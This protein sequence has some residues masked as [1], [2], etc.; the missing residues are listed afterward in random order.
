MFIRWPPPFSKSPIQEDDL[1]PVEQPSPEWMHTREPVLVDLF[2]VASDFLVAFRLAEPFEHAVCTL[3]RCGLMMTLC[4]DRPGVSFGG[5][6]LHIFSRTSRPARR[7]SKPALV[8][9]NSRFRRSPRFSFAPPSDEVNR[10]LSCKRYNVAW[11]AP[12]VMTR[13]VCASISFLTVTP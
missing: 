5:I 10:P 11:T 12:S 13:A 6:K 9:T 8:T 3:R 7:A 1:D 4:H 2:E